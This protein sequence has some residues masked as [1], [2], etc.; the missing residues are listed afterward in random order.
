M[1]QCIRKINFS[2]TKKNE[3]DIPKK[4]VR[5]TWSNL[6]SGGIFFFFILLNDSFK[7]YWWCTLFP[8]NKWRFF[9][10]QQIPLSPRAHTLTRLVS[11]LGLRSYD[12]SKLNQFCQK[13]WVT[14]F[15]SFCSRD[16]LS[17]WWVSE[18]RMHF[19]DLK[20]FFKQYS[21]FW[22]NLQARLKIWIKMKKMNKIKKKK[23]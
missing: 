15:F 14:S 22:D 11:L 18:R 4:I 23:C 10:C 2:P 21:K 1:V 5:S 7:C 8:S 17:T 19:L 3:R 12:R 20:I 6:I 13:R 9:F 16:V